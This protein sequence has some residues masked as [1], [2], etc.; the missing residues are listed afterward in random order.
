[1]PIDL[2]LPTSGR[3]SRRGS[4]PLAGG[5][6]CPGQGGRP[7]VEILTDKANVEI[8]SPVS[9]TVMKILASPGQVVKVGELLA[10]IE[11]GP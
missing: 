9:G 1:M 5:G 10:L 3:G 7:L 4:R 2:K 11:P 6:R 8:P